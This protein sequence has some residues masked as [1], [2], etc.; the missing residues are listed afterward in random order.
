[1]V[2]TVK[3]DS[4]HR[5]KRADVCGRWNNLKAG[6]RLMLT[7]RDTTA[8]RKAC[9]RCGDMR[10]LVRDCLHPRNCYR[11]KKHIVI[12]NREP[13]L[14][15]SKANVVRS[16]WY[17]DSGATNHACGDADY[18][19]SMTRSRP[20]RVRMATGTTVE[21][22]GRGE[23]AMVCMDKANKSREF[24]AKDVLYVP[25]IEANVLS[26]SQMAK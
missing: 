26:V 15:M 17:L 7:R 13:V 2:D 10:H 9:F 12:R 3:F 23:V 24:L 25:D 20:T 16:G 19:V 21:E 5:W 4:V 22:V 14:M 1:M 11:G 6:G 8:T 18:F